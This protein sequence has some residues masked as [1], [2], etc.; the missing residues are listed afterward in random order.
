MDPDAELSSSEITAISDAVERRYQHAEQDVKD[1]Q[2]SGLV[3]VITTHNSRRK[4]TRA[5]RWCVATFYEPFE[6]EILTYQAA[7]RKLKKDYPDL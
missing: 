3:E 7:Q 5:L 4:I 6:M 1:L 2:F